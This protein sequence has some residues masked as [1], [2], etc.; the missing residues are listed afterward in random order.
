MAS[1]LP[2]NLRD[3]ML[4]FPAPNCVELFRHGYFGQHVQTYYDVPY[5]MIVCAVLSWLALAAVRDVSIR[6]R[7]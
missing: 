5:T 1:W 7:R 3:I 4:L 2:E 6:V